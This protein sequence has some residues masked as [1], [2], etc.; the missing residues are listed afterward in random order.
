[1]KGNVCGR[2]IEDIG[3]RNWRGRRNEICGGVGIMEVTAEKV[4]DGG[5]R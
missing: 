2:V 4:G 1:M 5:K 3:H